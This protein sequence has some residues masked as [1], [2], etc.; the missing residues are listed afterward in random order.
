MVTEV[1]S[2]IFFLRK[3]L[4]LFEK[5]ES[6]LYLFNPSVESNKN[7]SFFILNKK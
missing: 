2:K 1:E 4:F 6:S 7:F 3:L 5:N